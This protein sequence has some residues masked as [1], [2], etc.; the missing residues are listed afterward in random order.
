M[1]E[2]NWQAVRA[3]NCLEVIFRKL[4]RGTNHLIVVIQRNLFLS[5][6]S[7]QRNPF[8]RN[9]LNGFHEDTLMISR[10]LRSMM[11]TNKIQFRLFRLRKLCG[12]ANSLL[13]LLTIRKQC[14]TFP[15][16]RLLA[17]G[18]CLQWTN[19]EHYQRLVTP[20]AFVVLIWPYNSPVSDALNVSKHR[21][22]I[23]SVSNYEFDS[24]CV[25]G[26]SHGILS[27]MVIE[28]GEAS[29]CVYSTSQA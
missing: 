17:N 7:I 28:F 19:F 11:W 25:P 18:K 9:P 29:S 22:L 20:D 2:A 15:R 6:E 23:I 27:W 26:E 16:D 13:T 3:F 10:C 21:A 8:Q 24:G 4:I 1:V 14:L 12:C 5:K